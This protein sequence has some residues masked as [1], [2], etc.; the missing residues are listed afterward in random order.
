MNKKPFL[1]IG[2]LFVALLSLSVIMSDVNATNSEVSIEV[3]EFNT[4]NSILSVSGY[5]NVEVL[6][7][8]IL[9]EKG[10]AIQEFAVLTVRDG[11]YSEKIVVRDGLNLERCK[12]AIFYNTNGSSS[13]VVYSDIVFTS[14]IPATSISLSD[15]KLEITA[16]Q[17]KTIVAS[18]LPTNTTDKIIWS[19]SNPDIVD[20]TSDGKLLPKLY[21]SGTYVDII[22]TAGTVSSTCSVKVEYATIL[23]SD[24]TINLTIGQSRLLSVQIPD[25]VQPDVIWHFSSIVS[26]DGSGTQITVTGE[27]AG[28]DTITAVVDNLY[29]ASCTVIVSEKPITSETYSFTLRI[30]SLSDAMRADYGSSGFS[31]IDLY[32]GLNFVST[33]TNAGV[34]LENALKEAEIP[35]DFYTGGNL[36]HWVNHIMGLGDEK[37]SDG[38]WR[39][40]IQTKGG[41]YNP[42]SLGYYTD[43]GTFEITYGITTE[44]GQIILPDDPIN[45]EQPHTHSWGGGVITKQPSCS[46]PGVMTY[47]CSCGE[48]RT[49]V[50]PASHTWSDWSIVKQATENE[51]G[52]KERTCS[53]CGRKE[54]QS[55]PKI[56]IVTNDDGSQKKTN[57]EVDGTVVS[58]T[59]GAK[60]G[61]TKIEKMKEDTDKDGNKV[62]ASSTE[63]IDKDGKTSIEKKV[64]IESKDGNVKSIVKI[65]NGADKVDIIT[66]VKTDSSDGNHAVTKE[67]IEQAIAIQGKVS[68]EIKGDVKD[69]SKVIQIVS[70]T[71][72]ASLT[73]P[74][75]AIKAASDANFSLRIVSEKGSIA[76]SDTVLSNISVE[77][78]I[79]I[80]ISEAKG[81]HINDVQREI[82]PDGAVVVVVRIMAGDKDLGKSLGGLITISIKHTSADGKIGVAYYIDD[83]GNKV[84]MGGIYDPIKGEIV[85]DSTH[86][87]LY[88]VVDEDPSKSG[89]S[90]TAIFVGI[91]VAVVAAIAVA[92]MLYVRKH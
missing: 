69:H 86:C 74:K 15:E 60:D 43:G 25:N 87:S 38:N 1:F 92:I 34:A 12:V 56:V 7:L 63:I 77:E 35:C 42:W 57:V 28:Y 55:I 17:S 36:K 32:N 49:E 6:K 51:N 75:D 11:L 72:D 5:S 26:L 33:G 27:Y 71:P 23:M 61:S 3:C 48:T 24:S 70:S 67:Q 59:T 68:D 20:I 89:L 21:S 41:S 73:V 18:V 16:G 80:S 46:E 8:S 65:P 50:I 79:T 37:L 58:T 4:N 81:E 19:S 40:W 53:V 14:S 82:I 2:I 39:Y 22:A 30:V 84:R 45:P 54:I 91:A 9:D 52:L 44:T 62:T 13:V 76:A 10:E 31:A 64:E 29:K 90:N 47:T 78:E 83:D 88:M 66:T 85:F